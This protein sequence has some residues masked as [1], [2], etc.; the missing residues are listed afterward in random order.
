MVCRMVW[1]SMHLLDGGAERRER[2]ARGAPGARKSGGEATAV[3]NTTTRAPRDRGE[4]GQVF[5]QRGQLV[6][7]RRRRRRQRAQEQ[8]RLVD[9]ALLAGEVGLLP[10]DVKRAELAY[11]DARVA[12]AC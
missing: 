5:V 12:E 9:N 8:Q 7:G 6:V 11:R 2:V 1:S 3:A 4:R 10:R